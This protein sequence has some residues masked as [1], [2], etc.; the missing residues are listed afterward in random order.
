MKKLFLILLLIPALG[1][2][3]CVKQK[4]CE[5][6]MVGTFQ[7]HD[8]PLDDDICGIRQAGYFTPIDRSEMY[9]ISV[10]EIPARFKSGDELKVRVLIEKMEA[11]YTLHC[12]YT[13]KL[14]CIE[15]ED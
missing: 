5:G 3:S 8:K 14:L 11:S 4:N 2:T 6:G 1:V 13:Y 9:R 15:K 10:R 7:Y 12:G